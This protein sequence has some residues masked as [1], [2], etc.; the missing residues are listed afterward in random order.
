MQHYKEFQGKLK[1]TGIFQEKRP[2]DRRKKMDDLEKEITI[3]K[4]QVKKGSGHLITF[5]YFLLYIKHENFT[6]GEESR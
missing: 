4:E 6:S 3:L 5:K 2:K 1:V